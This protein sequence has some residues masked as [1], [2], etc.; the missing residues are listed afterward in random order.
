MHKRM[1]VV[2]A[3]GAL[4]V[5]LA[6]NDKQFL[7]EQP[8]DFIGPTNFYRNA[9]DALA[10]I[11]GVYADFINSTGDNYYGRNF[12]MLVEHPTEMWT[13]RLSATNERSMSDVYS[14]FPGHAY[15][16]SVW[17]SAYDA[18]NRCNSVLD[19]V[20]SI[21]MDT[22]LRSR[23]VA[24]AKFLRATHYSGFNPDVS[25]LGI[26]NVNRGIDVG[27]YPLSRS[28]TFGINLTY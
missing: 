24:E 9:G 1:K 13:S 10:A 15:V 22:A 18:I 11:N 3:L 25:S 4:T 12:V 5:V 23:I 14:L 28:F 20:P 27:Q 19:H 21:D 17:Q 2:A 6:C 26:G 16:T 7:T 8:F